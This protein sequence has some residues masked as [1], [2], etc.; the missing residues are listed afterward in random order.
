[1]ALIS[2]EDRQS[3]AKAETTADKIREV[4]GSVK[5]SDSKIN[6][7]NITNELTDRR[8]KKESK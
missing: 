5:E 8:A 7:E 6:L 1:M 4:L 2:K 3:I